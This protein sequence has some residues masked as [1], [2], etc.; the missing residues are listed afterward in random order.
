MNTQI[1][2]FLLEEWGFNTKLLI[3]D[4]F[5]NDYD[6]DFRNYSFTTIP[7]EV[8]YTQVLFSEDQPHQKG[9]SVLDLLFCEG[10]MGRN[11]LIQ[12]SELYKQNTQ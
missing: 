1:T 6:L 4:S 8:N 11:I 9:L 3:T 10:P 2:E 12:N 5:R 7:N